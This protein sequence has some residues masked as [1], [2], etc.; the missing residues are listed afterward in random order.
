MPASNKRIEDMNK[1]ELEDLIKKVEKM[2]LSNTA[3]TIID[4]NKASDNE[5]R[6]LETI[7]KE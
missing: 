3:Q 6:L 5:L 2:K 4:K 1:E 7:R